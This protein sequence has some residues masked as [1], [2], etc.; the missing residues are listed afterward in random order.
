LLSQPTI[1]HCQSTQQE[2]RTVTLTV[3]HLLALLFLGLLPRMPVGLQ[4]ML[5]ITVRHNMIIRTHLSTEHQS[6]KLWRFWLWSVWGTT[7]IC[8][9][10]ICL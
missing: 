8:Q 10:E 5:V 1:Q 9:P 4:C 7:G 3:N 2:L 6:S